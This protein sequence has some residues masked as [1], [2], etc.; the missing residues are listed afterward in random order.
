MGIPNMLEYAD[1]PTVMQGLDEPDL[2][3]IKPI[4]I[5]GK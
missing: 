5:S 1:C 3:E 4:S 2:Q